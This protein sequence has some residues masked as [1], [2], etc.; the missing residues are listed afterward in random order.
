MRRLPTALLV[1]PLLWASSAAAQVAIPTKSGTLLRAEPRKDGAIAASL[2]GV[3]QFDW[4]K[5]R[6]IK[7]SESETR[8]TLEVTTIGGRAA[9]FQ[10]SD[11][12]LSR[13]YYLLPSVEEGE[14]LWLSLRTATTTGWAAGEE[15]QLALEKDWPVPEDAPLVV[16]LRKKELP[17]IKEGYLPQVS[18]FMPGHARASCEYAVLIGPKGEV[19]VPRAVVLS[20]VP[21]LE[22]HIE[23]V[24]RRWKFGKASLD[25][26][27]AFQLIRLRLEFVPST[28][29]LGDRP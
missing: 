4:S 16:P 9:D 26:N 22:N 12:Q 19:V 11:R 21:G 14:Q 10:E 13:V 28:D 7:I 20:G 29:R 17:K 24:L 25:G 27:P 6:T 8:G 3:A 18:G 1:W 15:V 23:P 5:A 2:D